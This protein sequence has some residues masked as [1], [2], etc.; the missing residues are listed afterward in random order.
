MVKA[1]TLCAEESHAFGFGHGLI[2]LD[3]CGYDNLITEES[4][5]QQEQQQLYLFTHRLQGI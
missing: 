2:L 3:F 1:S 4:Q 5:Q